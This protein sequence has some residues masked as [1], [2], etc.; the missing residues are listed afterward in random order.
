M[1][2]SENIFT[3]VKDTLVDALGIDDDDVTLEATLTEDLGV[4]SIDFLDI[5]FRLERLFGIQRDGSFFPSELTAD[6]FPID[7]HNGKFLH[8]NCLKDGIVT[9]ETFNVLRAK[10]RHFDV[11]A[12]SANPQNEN[13]RTI[14]TVQ[15][16]VNFVKNSL[17]DA[18]TLPDQNSNPVVVIR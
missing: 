12:V 6:R 7:I 17:A 11:D 9:G 16:L 15:S 3:K 1:D 4:S 13:F 14:F 10:T 8:S 5:S 18:G 2:S